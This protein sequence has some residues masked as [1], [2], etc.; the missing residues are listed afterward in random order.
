MCKPQKY[1][2]W[3]NRATWNVALWVANDE[4]RY[5]TFIILCKELVKDGKMWTAEY[6]LQMSIGAPLFHDGKTPDGD[7]LSKVNWDEIAEAWNEDVKDIME[8]SN[9]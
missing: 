9:V 6:A 1:N 3:T 8:A 4:A 5:D 7:L 2:G